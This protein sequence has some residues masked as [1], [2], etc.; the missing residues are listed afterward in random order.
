MAVA[1]IDQQYAYLTECGAGTAFVLDRKKSAK[2]EFYRLAKYQLWTPAGVV[3]CA[4]WK[5]CFGKDY[6]G[7]RRGKSREAVFSD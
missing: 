2:A 5:A 7:N 4:N 1:N 3:W 6:V